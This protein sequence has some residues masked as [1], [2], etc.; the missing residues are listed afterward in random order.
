MWASE[1]KQVVQV[2]WEESALTTG[3]SSK[4]KMDGHLITFL[5]LTDSFWASRAATWIYKEEK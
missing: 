4:D 3:N 1:R 5:E 2:L